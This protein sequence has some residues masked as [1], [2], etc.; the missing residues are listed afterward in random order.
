LAK[1]THAGRCGPRSNRTGGLNQACPLRARSAGET[2]AITVTQGHETTPL[3]LRS[4]WPTSPDPKPS[5]LAMRVRFPSPA[6]VCCIFSI[7]CLF[8]RHLMRP[9]VSA[10]IQFGFIL[11]KRNF[12]TELS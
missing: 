1:Q 6:L 4:G 9:T 8:S 2:G 7:Y 5:K 12:R 3:D 11:L 10:C